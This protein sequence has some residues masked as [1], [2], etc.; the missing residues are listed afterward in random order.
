MGSGKDG[1]GVEDALPPPP[2]VPPNV[3]PI[4]AEP[5]HA[6]EPIKKKVV[7]LPIARRGFGSKGQKIALT[8][9]HFKVN[10]TAAD[11]NFFHYSV[12][13]ISLCCYSTLLRYLV[14]MFPI[15]Y[16]FLFLLLTG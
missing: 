9:N 16:Y 6:P 7:R 3:V 14:V 4:R 11:G 13:F 1:N 12:S 10:V 15:I 2:P 5:E 8:T